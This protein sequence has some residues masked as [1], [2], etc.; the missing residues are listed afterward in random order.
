MYNIKGTRAWIFDYG[1]TLDT[2]GHHWGRVLWHFWQQAGVPVDEQQFRDAYVFAERMLGSQPIIKRDFTFYQTLQE[3]LR[4]ELQQVECQAYC[5]TLLDMIYESTR[6]HTVHS[7]EVLQ[8]LEGP[9]VLVTNF[10]GNM[11]T[12]L[13]EF[14]L[15]GLFLQ[16]IESALVGVRKPDPRIFQLGVEA[17]G[18]CADEV[19]VVGDSLSKDIAPAR[20]LG[21]HTIWLRGEQWTDA[22]VDESAAECI[23]ND[24]EELL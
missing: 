18:L 24:L 10:Y 12:V 23:I 4:I 11:P 2:G 21:C 9:K 7:R 6:Q 20:R 19:T 8:K 17:L 13:R 22:A 3:K 5:A 1:G 14:G 15:D 16:V